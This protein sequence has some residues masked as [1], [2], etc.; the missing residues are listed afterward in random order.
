MWAVRSSSQSGKT[1]SFPRLSRCQHKCLSRYQKLNPG[2]PGVFAMVDPKQHATR[3]RLFAQPFSNS[4]MLTLEPTIK[5]RIK[6]AV[7]KIRRDALAGNADVLKWFTF[8]ATDISGEL[9][10]GKSFEMLQQ[11]QVCPLDRHILSVCQQEDQHQPN[12]CRKH[13]I[14]RTSKLPS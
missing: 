3:R 2:P 7:S 11:E 9:S 12:A 5:E 8:L 6:T 13:H 4:N 10:F 1:Y 14:S